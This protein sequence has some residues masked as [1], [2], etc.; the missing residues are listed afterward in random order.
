MDKIEI[1]SLNRTNYALF[2]SKRKNRRPRALSTINHYFESAVNV[3]FPRAHVLKVQYSHFTPL[4]IKILQNPMSNMQ[5]RLIF[6]HFMMMLVMSQKLQLLKFSLSFYFAQLV[7]LYWGK[8]LDYVKQ[9]VTQKPH[10][11]NENFAFI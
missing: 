6:V 9:T 4:S 10:F 2:H 5:Q 7:Y 11:E 1:Q 8:T 3:F